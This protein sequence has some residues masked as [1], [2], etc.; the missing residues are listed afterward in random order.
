MLP[1]NASVVL[2]PT[3]GLYEDETID[4]GEISWFSR[5]TGEQIEIQKTI[6]CSRA[7]WEKIRHDPRVYGWQLLPLSTGVLAIGPVQKVCD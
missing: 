4:H 6:R 1:S 2:S 5:R 3:N 7:V